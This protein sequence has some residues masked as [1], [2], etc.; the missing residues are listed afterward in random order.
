MTE[1]V[2]HR[3]RGV[4]VERDD[5]GL[6]V[7]VTLHISRGCE[8]TDGASRLTTAQAVAL[9]HKHAARLRTRAEELEDVADRLLREEKT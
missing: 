5:D 1:R 9:L 6:R 4:R 3:T 2:I 8:Y 7:S